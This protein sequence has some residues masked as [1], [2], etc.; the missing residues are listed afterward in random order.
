MYSEELDFR[1]VVSYIVIRITYERIRI[2]VCMSVLATY[3]SLL[4]R[5]LNAR[6]AA[7]LGGPPPTTLRSQIPVQAPLVQQPRDEQPGQDAAQI[8]PEDLRVGVRV[9]PIDWECVPEDLMARVDQNRV[10]A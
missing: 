8:A 9:P 4:Y 3:S 5:G 2:G 10:H 6:P 1:G 7:G